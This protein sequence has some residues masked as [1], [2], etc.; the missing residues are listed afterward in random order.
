MSIKHKLL[1][2]FA[3]MVITNLTASTISFYQM[4][5]IDKQYSDTIN[6]GLPKLNAVSDIRNS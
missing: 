5:G 6:N 2:G 1:A 4:I 3:L